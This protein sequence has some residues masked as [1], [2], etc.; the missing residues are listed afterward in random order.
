MFSSLASLK[1]WFVLWTWIQ[2]LRNQ[3]RLSKI[4]NKQNKQY[5]SQNLRLRNFISKIMYFSIETYNLVH[6]SLFKFPYIRIKTNLYF[7][8]EHRD[9]EMPFMLSNVNT[10]ARKV[11]KRTAN[12]N[13]HQIEGPWHPSVL[14]KLSR[15]LRER[16]KGSLLK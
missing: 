5:W 14:R 15:N 11:T 10:K 6:F 7:W 13:W 16:K 1:P 4:M 3:T 9:I 12:N 8:L 2:V